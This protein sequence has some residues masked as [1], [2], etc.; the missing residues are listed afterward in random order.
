MPRIQNEARIRV[1]TAGITEGEW[2]RLSARLG[3]TIR[4]VH[5][6]LQGSTQSSIRFYALAHDDFSGAR[7]L[8]AVEYAGIDFK[9]D[10]EHDDSLVTDV[11][12][13]VSREEQ[14][15]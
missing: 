5:A 8:C 11:G 7:A 14:A 2:E 4:D 1:N 3:E 9:A 12:D 6:V 15:N 10:T 13:L